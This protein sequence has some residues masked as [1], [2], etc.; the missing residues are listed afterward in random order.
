MFTRLIVRNLTSLSPVCI[1][2][3]DLISGKDLSQ[4]IFEAYNSTGLGIL[5][6]K[7]IISYPEKRKKLLP[8]ARKL[9]L[10]SDSEKSELEQP[11]HSYS[12]GWSH[13]KEHFAGEPDYSKGS[14]YANPEVDIPPEQEQWPKNI[15]PQKSIHEFEHAFKDLGQEMIRVGSLL[16]T[17]IDKFIKAFHPSYEEGTISSIIK[18]HK[19]HV[20]RL[21]HYFPQ[22]GSNKAWCGWHNDHCALTALTSSMYLNQTTGEIVSANETTELKVGLFI[23][24]R[25]GEPCK[26]RAGADELCFQIGETAQILSGGVL[27]AT[28]HVVFNDGSLENISRNTFAVFMEP[29]PSFVLNSADP[30]KVFYDHPDV[31]SLRARWSPGMTFGQFHQNTLSTFN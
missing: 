16:G 10:L 26:I 5:T 17:H 11:E 22:S 28:P 18:N 23:K 12:I 30:E 2:Y 15:W 3:T 14:F 19:S 25:Q 29:R 6:I 27:K 21:L 8:L 4:E 13:G 31:P 20:G 9:A 1:D 24:N 7:N